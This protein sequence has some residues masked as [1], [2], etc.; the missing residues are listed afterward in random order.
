MILCPQQKVSRIQKCKAGVSRLIIISKDRL[1]DFVL[2]IPATLGPVVLDD[3]D[4]PK[5]ILLTM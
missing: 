2:S 4:P 3:P 1:G 5:C